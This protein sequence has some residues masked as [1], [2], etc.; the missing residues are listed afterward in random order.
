[1]VDFQNLP[2]WSVFVATTIISMTF[3]GI[4]H[5]HFTWFEWAIK[6]S[7]TWAICGLIYGGENIKEKWLVQ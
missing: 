6:N 7:V 2:L 3:I 1:M 5:L 4:E